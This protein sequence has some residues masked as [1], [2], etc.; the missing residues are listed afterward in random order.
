MSCKTISRVLKPNETMHVLCTVGM[1]HRSMANVISPR[2]RRLVQTITAAIFMGSCTLIKTSE[3]I[4]PESISIRHK[5]LFC[6]LYIS[7][8]PRRR[9]RG[10]RGNDSVIGSRLHTRHSCDNFSEFSLRSV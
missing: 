2:H 8:Q 6:P 5:S 9:T 4:L 7:P 10:G 3:P 1:E